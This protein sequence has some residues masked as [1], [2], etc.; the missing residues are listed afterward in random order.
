MDNNIV[1]R[2]VLI[3]SS[4][5]KNEMDFALLCLT[6][7]SVSVKAQYNKKLSSQ[8]LSIGFGGMNYFRGYLNGW[9]ARIFRG[10]GYASNTSDDGDFLTVIIIMPTQ[11]AES[12]QL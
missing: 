4:H 9:S 12:R 3:I 11:E 8:E 6:I 7:L 1:T 5:F 10:S 2:F